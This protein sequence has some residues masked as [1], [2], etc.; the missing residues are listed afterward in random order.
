MQLF[1]EH[2][3]ECKDEVVQSGAL[4]VAI[5]RNRGGNHCGSH[6]MSC[7]SVGVTISHSERQG[8]MAGHVVP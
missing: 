8:S 5:Y 7:V 6:D 4:M 1:A 3:N 2:C